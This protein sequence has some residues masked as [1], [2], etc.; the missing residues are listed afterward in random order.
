MYNAQDINV[1][2]CD[3]VNKDTLFL[4]YAILHSDD[5]LRCTLVYIQH[6]LLFTCKMYLYVH[7]SQ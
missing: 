7:R 4:L 2:V 5:C 3:K 1:A 6:L